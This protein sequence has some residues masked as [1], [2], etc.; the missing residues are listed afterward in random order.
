MK[1]A[2]LVAS[3][4]TAQVELSWAKVD[5]KSYQIFYDISLIMQSYL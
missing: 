1:S 3:L 4:A 2:V 5:Q